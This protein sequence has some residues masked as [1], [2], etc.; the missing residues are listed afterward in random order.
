[1]RHPH[2]VST[3]R[4]GARAYHYPRSAWWHRQTLY[5]SH[6][7]FKT[8]GGTWFRTLATGRHANNV[9]R[10]QGDRNGSRGQ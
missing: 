2:G 6:G 3:G 4:F 1:M 9:S 8:F 10:T 5:N 7:L